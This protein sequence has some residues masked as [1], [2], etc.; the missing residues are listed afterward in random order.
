[1]ESKDQKSE[2]TSTKLQIDGDKAGN[3]IQSVF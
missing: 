1:V 3:R 2:G